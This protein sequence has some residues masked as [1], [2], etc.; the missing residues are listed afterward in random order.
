MSE[1]NQEQQNQ[2]QATN[3][4][5]RSRPI[6]RP[7]PALIITNSLTLKTPEKMTRSD[8]PRIDFGTSSVHVDI[9]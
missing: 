5:I 1:I 7:N 8:G 2:F 6:G 9:S 4:K 3:I